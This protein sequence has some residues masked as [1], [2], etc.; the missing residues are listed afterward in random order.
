MTPDPF[1]INV[2]FEVVRLREVAKENE[3]VYTEGML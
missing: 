2:A 1:T 3:S